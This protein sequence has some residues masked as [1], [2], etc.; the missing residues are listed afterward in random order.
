M[1]RLVSP[2]PRT[3]RR[4]AAS[5]G[6]VTQDI[7]GRSATT[8]HQLVADDLHLEAWG[9][10]YRAAL[11]TFFVLCSSGGA[12][13]NERPLLGLPYRFMS[14]H[15]RNSVRL[16]PASVKFFLSHIATQLELRR[17]YSCA[18]DIHSWETA[19]RVDA[20]ASEDKTGIGGWA[21]VVNSEGSL[22]PWQTLCFSYELT[23]TGW[24]WIFKRG[25]KPSFIISTLEALAV[26]MSLKL[27]F[28]D[29]PKQGRTK[30]QVVPTRTDNRGNG[31]AL[32]ELMSTKFSSGAVL[33]LSCYLKRMAG[34]LWREWPFG[35]V[36]FFGFL[37]L[38]IF[39]I[40]LL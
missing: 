30:V 2:P 17:H 19:P 39:D 8:W 11:I 31:S 12:L 40:C 18:V 16:V 37:G 6:R 3:T 21:L 25:N 9:G 34:R 10:H 13:E 20:Q 22:D 33:E 1:G 26:L 36:D 23:R 29:E 35:S 27:F 5:I 38:L 4:V 24:P 7:P 28:G 32:N 14:L 15:P